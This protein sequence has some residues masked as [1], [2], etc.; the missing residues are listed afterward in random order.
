MRP[1]HEAEYEDYVHSS[2]TPLFRT[3][4]ALT[5]DYQLAED[6]LQTAL[7]KTFVRWSRVRQLEYR[8]AY[9]RK[10]MANQAISWWRRRSSS[11]LPSDRQ[12]EV[13]DRGHEDGVADSQ[14]M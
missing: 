2:W 11:E 14:S 4:F 5:G 8:D 13:P 1:R 3:A 10:I 9:M 6:L 12:D 7:T